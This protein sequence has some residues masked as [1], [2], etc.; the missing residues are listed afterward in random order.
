VFG[1]GTAALDRLFRRRKPAL[2]D[3]PATVRRPGGGR[4]I[5]RKATADVQGTDVPG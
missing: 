1:G 5:H 3:D 4:W 2:E